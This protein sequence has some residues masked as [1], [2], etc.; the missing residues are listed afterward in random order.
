MIVP[1]NPIDVFFSPTQFIPIND[2]LKF[3]LTIELSDSAHMKSHYAI[4]STQLSG[5]NVGFLRIPR[6]PLYRAGGPA[7][8]WNKCD[9]RQGKSV[10]N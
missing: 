9:L 10:F 3:S 7:I 6:P 1:W 8:C 4:K 5:P 2:G